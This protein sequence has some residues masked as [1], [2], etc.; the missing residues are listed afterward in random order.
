[1]QL[2]SLVIHIPKLAFVSALWHYM[3]EFGIFTDG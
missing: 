2:I 1:M 3:V